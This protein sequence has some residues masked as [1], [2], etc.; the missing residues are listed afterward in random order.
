MKKLFRAKFKQ[1]FSEK[2]ER[3][4]INAQNRIL[5]ATGPLAILWNGAEKAKKWAKILILEIL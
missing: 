3:S 2:K 5:D 4:I 1:K